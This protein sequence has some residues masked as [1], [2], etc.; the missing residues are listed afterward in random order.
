LLSTS[1]Y[2]EFC[3][4]KAEALPKV[5][6]VYINCGGRTTTRISHF[7][8]PGECSISRLFLNV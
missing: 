2:L 4:F 1:E 7:I 5:S 3:F 8:Q 6:E